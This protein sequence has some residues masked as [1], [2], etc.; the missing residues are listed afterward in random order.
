MARSKVPVGEF[1]GPDIL[2][3]AFTNPVTSRNR[4]VDTVDTESQLA[5]RKKLLDEL[6]E[7]RQ[8]AADELSRLDAQLQEAVREHEAI[9]E[10]GRR[11]ERLSASFS[12]RRGHWREV[13]SRLVREIE[14]ATPSFVKDAI[15][16]IKKFS[17]VGDASRRER[18]DVAKSKLER[19][20][21]VADVTK[22]DA[23]AILAELFAG[24]VESL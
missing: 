23:K 24:E 7:A 21:M 6:T 11:R 22:D 2:E 4:D 5:S 1:I 12:M 10:I 20:V 17:E 3:P 8:S 13:E 16:Q 14:A 9:L 15:Q 18:C 19:L